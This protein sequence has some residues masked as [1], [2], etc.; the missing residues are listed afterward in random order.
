MSHFEYVTV[1][2]SIILAL[3]V[4]RLLDGIG[5]ALRTE[6]RY[7][8]HVGWM[9]IIF[10]RIIMWWWGLW[11]ARDSQW[12]LGIFLLELGAPIV[13]YLQAKSLTTPS[14]SSPASW[15]DRFEEIRVPFFIGNFST[16]CLAFGLQE[17]LAIEPLSPPLLI[18]GMIMSIIGASFR[19]A[20]LQGVL[21]CIALVTTVLAVGGSVFTVD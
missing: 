2:V 5:E 17:V 13:F 16:V 18:F 19:N 8:I 20:R 1:A 12:N 4:A 10:L 7:W 3:G 11:V 6:A 14:R 21:V 9:A 15:A